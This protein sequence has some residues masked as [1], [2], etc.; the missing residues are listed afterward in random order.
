MKK[1]ETPRPIYDK[2]SF[3]RGYE[4]G[5]GVGL[6]NGYDNGYGVGVGI[7]ERDLRI[8][9]LEELECLGHDLRLGLRH[10]LTTPLE[11]LAAVVELIKEHTLALDAV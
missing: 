10:D 1:T 8:Y 4:I 3:D 7:G 11:V 9:L 6:D 2:R 5:E